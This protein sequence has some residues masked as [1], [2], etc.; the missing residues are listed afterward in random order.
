M[1]RGRTIEALGDAVG[2]QRAV[3][4]AATLVFGVSMTLTTPVQAK[5]PVRQGQA[6][7]KVGAQVEK[8]RWT[9]TCTK[10]KGKK[11][12]VR[13][14]TPKP[15]PAPVWQQVASQ[16]AANADE[17]RTSTPAT[18]FEFIASPTISTSSAAQAE[19][20]VE[21]AYETWHAVAPLPAD[22]HVYLVDAKSEDWYREVS[23]EYPNDTCG[24]YWWERTI[25]T[26]A[27]SGGAVCGSP[28]HE[29]AYMVLFLGTQ[30][31]VS[32]WL[33]T[34]EAVHVAQGRLLGSGLFNM[35]CWIGEGMAELYT[36]ALAI[37]PPSAGP[38][39]ATQT[40]RNFIVGGLR[41]LPT[42]SADL[43][44][45]D[46]WLDVIRQSENR[47]SELCRN[48]GLGYSLGY[49]VSERLIADFGE[50]RVIE[51][52]HATHRLGDS[53]VAFERTFGM[54]KDDWYTQSAAPYVA[55][56][57]VTIIK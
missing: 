12:W 48:Y 43:P 19:R 31:T 9:F 18:D 38:W 54:A 16:L 2:A 5:S 52:L 8:G 25:A 26:P 51:W 30:S 50:S 42:T 56:E 32:T 23:S 24:A 55:S 57:V 7:S 17:R 20:A 28:Q 27:N 49:L 11:V 3:V 1:F 35:E 53:G 13:K 4:L 10:K 21:R 29:W 37:P 22:F 47:G 36:G 33:S 14:R 41:A 44:N 40:Y 45:P 46:Y 6:C 34:H 39:L 15:E